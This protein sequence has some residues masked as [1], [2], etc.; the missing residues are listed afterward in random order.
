MQAVA[1][2]PFACFFAPPA[3]S[4][5]L[6]RPAAHFCP[7][8]RFNILCT[9][10]CYGLAACLP[11]PCFAC[12]LS[13]HTLQLQ[14]GCRPGTPATVNPWLP[15]CL[16]ACLRGLVCTNE[17][18]DSRWRL[19]HGQ[20]G[21]AQCCGARRAAGGPSRPVPT[22]AGCLPYSGRW[23]REAGERTSGGA[24]GALREWLAS[25]AQGPLSGD[26]RGLAGQR[27]GA[28]SAAWYR[29]P[30]AQ[31]AVP[32]AICAV[33]ARSALRPQP[34]GGGSLLGHAEQRL[35]APGE[36]L[37]PVV[38]SGNGCMTEEQSD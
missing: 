1:S 27:G 22:A 29:R 3:L 5:H 19:W 15:L 10:S 23:R 9:C 35:G 30:S 16:P 37:G 14:R 33:S 25:G 12:G 34:C 11:P 38:C 20:W 2:G 32:A 36:L 28:G 13:I 6:P 8:C 18:R 7:Y 24:T 4:A 31:S 21:S 26:T 17:R